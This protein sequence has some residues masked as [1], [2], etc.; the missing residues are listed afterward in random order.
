[1]LRRL[2]E[3]E[4]A[5]AMHQLAQIER[6]HW[7]VAEMV[8]GASVPGTCKVGGRKPRVALQDYLD[9]AAKDMTIQET[10]LHLGVTEDA[11]RHMKRKYKIQ[12]R[13][14]QRG[15]KSKCRST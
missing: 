5:D 8:D 2:T 10:I 12:F 7:L 11:A 6:G 1:M 15:R 4:L 13:P 9:C 14:G 3:A